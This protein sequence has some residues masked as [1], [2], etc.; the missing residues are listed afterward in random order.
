MSDEVGIEEISDPFK[1]TEGWISESE[2]VKLL[3]HTLYPDISNFLAFHLNELA[4][5]EPV[6]TRPLKGTSRIGA[7]NCLILT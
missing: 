2:G 7:L 6:I 5:R 4:S 3:P 1:L